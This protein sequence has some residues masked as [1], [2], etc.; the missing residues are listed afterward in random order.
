MLAT[1]NMEELVQG[2][3]PEILE[4]MLLDKHSPPYEEEFREEREVRKQQFL[5]GLVRA[6]SYIPLR[7]EVSNRRKAL[8]A[9]VR[10]YFSLMLRDKYPELSTDI[11]ALEREVEVNIDR[12]NGVEGDKK[13]K[14]VFPVFLSATLEDTIW[15]RQ[16]RSEGKD[17]YSTY[18]L[19][20][21]T[22]VPQPTLEVREKAKETVAYCHDLYSDALKIT[23]L[24]D[25]LMSDPEFPNP[26]KAG[27]LVLW[28]P[29]PEDMYVEMR[30]IDRDPV[31]TL[32][33]E[34]KL[35]LV[36]TWNVEEEL[37]YERF[38]IENG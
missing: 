28:R 6:V 27:L 10:E 32:N 23:C 38:L 29:R 17:R 33:W 5:E 14:F 11:L 12:Y 30:E 3:T 24:G 9:M 2:T 37:P 1:P 13:A 35:Y 16:F 26:T 36:T 20:V 4:A 22:P 15:K 34:D 21:S 7:T 18:E 31:L 19:K 8:L 25:L